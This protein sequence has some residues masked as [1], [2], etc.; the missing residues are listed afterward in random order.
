MHI[1]TYLDT[2]VASN[3]REFGT[4]MEMEMEMEMYSGSL[5]V[6]TY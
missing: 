4:G 5:Y 3:D 1:H 6:F 2:L